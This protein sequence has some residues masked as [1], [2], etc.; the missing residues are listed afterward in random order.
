MK[1]PRTTFLHVLWC[2]LMATFKKRIQPYWWL[3]SLLA[4][5][6]QRVAMGDLNKDVV[7]GKRTVACKEESITE[8]NCPGQESLKPG[9]FSS[10][11]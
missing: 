6:E 2:A 10:P 4:A 11:S 1:Q 7:Q 9:A 3:W 8:F 5:L